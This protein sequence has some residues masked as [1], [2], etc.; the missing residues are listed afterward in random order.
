MLHVASGVAGLLDGPFL[1]VS[2]FRFQGAEGDEIDLVSD[3][4]P[5]DVDAFARALE[6]Y[7]RWRSQVG[8]T[9]RSLQ[10]IAKVD[11]SDGENEP[12]KAKAVEKAGQA[13]P[14]DAA[15]NDFRALNRGWEDHLQAFK[16]LLAPIEGVL[17]AALRRG[18]APEGAPPTAAPDVVL[19]VDKALAPIPFEAMEV[20]ARCASVTREFCLHMMASRLKRLG[21]SF[22]AP[23]DAAQYLVDMKEDTRTTR[24]RPGTRAGSPARSSRRSTTGS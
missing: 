19:M 8:K 3:R 21:G 17:E 6:G 9:I 24:P 16:A 10:S 22:Q 5:F 1:Y 15:L 18:E 20:F 14:A 2:G 13:A 23:L 4:V 11:H 12:P 7:R